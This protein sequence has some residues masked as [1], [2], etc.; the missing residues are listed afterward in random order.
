MKCAECGREITDD[1][2]LT[3]LDNWLQ[4]EH[5]TRCNPEDR[6]FCSAQCFADSWMLEP[7]YVEEAEENIRACYEEES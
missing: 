4:W 1:M 6:Y 7:I 2:V 5:Y 3:P